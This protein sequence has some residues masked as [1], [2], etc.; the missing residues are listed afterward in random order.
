MLNSLWLWG[1]GILPRANAQWTCVAGA[2]PLL[3]GLARLAG[4]R[5]L[6]LEGPDALPDEPRVL[7]M[8]TV[9]P[10]A[11]DWEQHILAVASTWIDALVGKLAAG[12]LSS[13]TVA[14]LANGQ[15]LEW[16]A[17]RSDLRKFWRRPRPLATP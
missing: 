10:A 9:E 16:T 17:T 14:T 7:V 5:F 12:R 4:I 6:P 2:N 3:A 11:G 8:P 1:G 15:A 13:L